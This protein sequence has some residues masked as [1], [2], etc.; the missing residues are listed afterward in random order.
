MINPSIFKAYDIRGIYPKDINEENI[1]PI[2]QAI[3]TFFKNEL[4]KWNFTVVLGRDMRTSSPQL[5]E[6]AKNTLV[7]SGANVVDIGL[8][9]TPTVYFATLDGKYDSGIQIS[10]S[11]NPKDY[12]G[13]K[14]FIREDKKLK[15]ISSKYGMNKIKEFALSEKFKFSRN[16]GKVIVKKDILNREI[17]Y[18]I[19]LVKPII[20]SKFKIAV[21]AANA[22]GSIFI[23]RLL[24]RLNVN[25]I[26]MNFELDGTFPSHQPDPLQF[27]LLAD[28]QKKVLKTKAD[29]GIAPDGD[30]DRVFFIDEKGQIIPATLISCL[31][32]SELFRKNKK[33]K[34]V[35]DIRYTGNVTNL[36]KKY[37]TKPSYCPIGHALITAQL[38]AENADFAGESSGHYYF[39]ETGGA[40]SSIRVILYILKAMSESNLPISKI[41]K[42][43]QTSYESGEFNFE[44]NEKIS[45]KQILDEIK[46]TYKDGELNT[47]DGIAISYPSWRFSIRTSNT[48]P[49]LR[50]N[51]EGD[52]KTFVL[53]KVKELSDKITR[54][55]A[56]LKE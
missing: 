47:I 27:K 3:Y 31:I 34:I 17:D 8:S 10:A 16:K 21:D 50:L 52:S 48:E 44:I 25:L 55:G 38:N 56:K 30:G 37:K 19:S 15:K 32:A 26:K 35:V 22:M 18:A 4:K 7:N 20:S 54:I 14:L 6:V 46:D 33:A 13:I 9:S 51:I 45:S 2:I 24:S 49:L 41:I 39:K 5:F 43:Y 23:D 40:E 42:K 12:A 29:F 1:V 36:C 28:L 11:H 53:A